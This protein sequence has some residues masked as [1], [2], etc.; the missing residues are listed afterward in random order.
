LERLQPAALEEGIIERYSVFV[1]I[2]L[3]HVSEYDDSVF[4]KVV[5]CLELLLS[6]LGKTDSAGFM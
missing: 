1:S 5:D 6:N 4:Y 3:N 2:V